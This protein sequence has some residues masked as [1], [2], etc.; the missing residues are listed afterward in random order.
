MQ[1]TKQNTP[2]PINYQVQ[3][4][5]EQVVATLP[6]GTDLGL[7][8]VI[9]A[10][11]SGYFIETGGAMMPAVDLY[12]SQFDL[13]ESERAA[14]SRRAAKAVTYGQYNLEEL[15]T[16]LQ[17]IITKDEKWSAT[18]VQGYTLK[19]VD[20][21]SYKRSSVKVLKSK[22]YDATAGRA[23][24]A[25]PFGMMGTVGKVGEQRMVLLDMLYSGCTTTNNPSDDTKKVYQG[26]AKRLKEGELA[27]FDAGF[28]MI[29]ACRYGVNNYVMRLSKNC[30]FGKTPGKVPPRTSNK[31]RPP[32]RHQAEIVRPLARQHGGKE[33]PAS[34][35][36]ETVTIITEDGL[37]ITIEVW[38]RVY[39]LER[40]LDKVDDEVL[41]E[42]LRHTPLKVVAIHHPDFNDP[43]VIGTTVLEL[44][45]ESLLAIYP[46]RW[47][48]EGVPQT[49]KYLLSGGGG[50]H[51]VH[52][53]TAI[54]RLPALSMIFGSLFKYLAAISP[55]I[56]SGFWDR[57]VKPTYG[58]LLRYLKK[59]GIP[60]S[61]QL[62]KKASI[63]KH[64]PIGYEAIR[65]AKARK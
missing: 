34:D 50:R 26:V 38:S 28:S 2:T 57:I 49:G 33:I 13:S 45:A 7:C 20:N 25:V 52:H 15:L 35:A 59:V 11:W 18:K 9:S 62:S 1:K 61:S 37:S 60:L 41:K 51:Y 39:F 46:E 29:E 22:S 30:T 19:S 5:I 47:P 24:P 17:E 53:P 54:V 43:L 23:L 27:I 65:L 16:K 63:T 3:Q 40:H 10:M 21:T 55:P 32:S 36:D 4:A 56:R 44:T 14:R 8:D 12:L 64:L 48:I 6:K 58:R 42:K 31:G